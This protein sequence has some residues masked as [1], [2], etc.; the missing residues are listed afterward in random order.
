M[1]DN[2]PLLD[3]GLHPRFGEIRPDHILPA[4]E[5]VIAQHRAAMRRCAEAQGY[6]AI[7]LAKDRADAALSRVWQTVSHLVGVAN[8]PELR[9]AHGEVQPM[10]DSYFAEVG[11]DRAL[12]DALVAIP[13][14]GLGEAEARALALTLQGFELSGVGLDDEEREAF[15]ANSVAQGRLATE[16]ANAVMD[17]TEAW[18][19]HVTDPARLAGVPESDRGAMAR[20]AE[21]KGLDGWLIDLHAPSVRAITGFADDRDLRRTVYE[22]YGTRASDQGPHAGQFDN[23]DRITQLLALRQEAA[24]LLGYAD[25]VA[26]SLS[27]KMAR[28]G[29]EVDAFLVDLAR[30][31]RPHAERELAELAKFA[32]AQLGIDTLEP[33]DIAYATERMRRAVHALD[34]AEIRAHLPLARILDGLFALVTELY[35]VDIRPADGAPVWHEDVRYFTVHGADGAPVA[36]LYCDLF[37]RAGKRGGAWMDVCRPRLREADAV[38]MPIAYLVCNFASGSAGRPAH[39]THQEM[40][41]LFHEMGHCL[42]HLLTQVDVPSV[43]GISGVEWDAVELPSQFMENFAWEPAMLR[44]VSAHEES[45]QPLDEAMIGRMLAARRFMGAVALLRQVEFALFDLRLHQSAAQKDGPSVQQIV[46]AVRQDV[47]VIHP[48]AWHRFSHS[49]SHIFAGGYAAGYYSYLWAERLS[50]DAF[51]AFAEEKADRA[52]LGGLFRDHVL[53]RGG[54]RPAIDNFVAFRG[55]Q[56]DSAALLRALGLAA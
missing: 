37:A 44:R 34:E 36:A 42:H 28:D 32:Q 35:G 27:T 33:W 10:I 1:T 50:A 13:R 8:T 25:P 24:G 47:A 22:A 23:S 9:A 55:R 54:S 5:T 6:D 31:A 18:T 12:Y 17:A 51:E 38:Q 16:F 21:A 29:E 53:A 30:R 11:Q 26:L 20:A 2:N 49:F 41:T 40:V 19:L 39:L 45:G 52:A 46:A 56:P 4:V 15:A 7:F 43:G 14:D 3:S 48:P